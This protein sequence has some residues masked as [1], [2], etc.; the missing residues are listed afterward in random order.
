MYSMKNENLR[1]LTCPDLVPLQFLPDASD[2][3]QLTRKTLRISL[4]FLQR[5]PSKSQKTQSPSWQIWK[6]VS[7]RFSCTSGEE[8]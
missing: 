4:V 5:Y 2:F 8:G 7:S 6:Q 3:F 1:T